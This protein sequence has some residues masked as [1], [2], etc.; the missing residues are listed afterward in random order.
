MAHVFAGLIHTAYLLQH[1]GLAPPPHHHPPPTRAPNHLP[2][3]RLS[4][5]ADERLCSVFTLFF[6]KRCRFVLV[7]LPC[8][9]NYWICAYPPTWLTFGYLLPCTA[10]RTYSQS[11]LKRLR[12]NYCSQMCSTCDYRFEPFKKRY[13]LLKEKKASACELPRTFRADYWQ[14]FRRRASA[15]SS[16]KGIFSPF[17]SISVQ[18]LSVHLAR[19]NSKGRGGAG[20]RRLKPKTVTWELVLR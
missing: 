14:V 20:L 6:F 16:A 15:D 17:S 3:P 12:S 19:T 2:T 13:I 8:S 18:N 4:P 5:P 1:L 10:F 11:G 7:L 9:C